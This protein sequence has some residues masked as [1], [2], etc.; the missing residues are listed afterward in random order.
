MP[1]VVT[2]TRIPEVKLIEPAVY[3]DARGS[4]MESFNAREFAELVAAD[5]VF[6][7]DNISESR[8]GVVR[9]LHYQLPPFAQAKLVRCIAGAI[10]DVAVDVRRNS[11]TLGQ[12][13]GVEL[14][15]MNKKSL[16]IPEGFAHGFAVLG[17]SASVLYKHTAL[18]HPECEAAICWNDPT[19]AI[20][21]PMD[22]IGAPIVSDKDAKAC[23]WAH[24]R[25]FE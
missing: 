1:I 23:D 10:F 5:V 11:P 15:A 6:L 16:W 4:F 21:W 17:E 7:Q 19:L 13:V 25:L 2:P 14:S 9:G 3:T 18:W 24:A 20:A 12:W 8:K 22:K